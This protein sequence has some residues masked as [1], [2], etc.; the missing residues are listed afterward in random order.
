VKLEVAVAET[1]ATS[2]DL[3]I[4]IAAEEV[5]KKFD[6][7]WNSYARYAA[8]PGFRPGKVP[9]NVIKQRFAKDA[10]D[11]V[12]SDL[13]PHALHH[14]IMDHKLRVVGEP[15]VSELSVKEGEPLKFKVSVEIVPDFELKD[16]KSLRVTKKLRQV[17]DE[18]V[19]HTLEHLREN[20]AQ[21]V[22]VEDRVSQDGDYV[23][24]DLIGNYVDPK[25]KHE[26]E[27]IKAEGV[28]FEINAEGVQPEFTENL[29]GVRAGDIREFRVDYPE[30]FAAQG[31]AGKSV[32]FKAT[33]V[34]VKVRELPEINDEFAQE[35]SDKQ[36]LAELREQ[37]RSDQQ[38]QAEYQADQGV[39]DRLMDQLVEAHDFPVPDVMI[40]QQAA[41]LSRRY[42][43]TLM[44]LRVP[45]EE[46]KQINWEERAKQDRQRAVRDV[47][48]ALVVGRV[49][50]AENITVTKEEMETEITRMAASMR[51][52]P[53]DLKAALTKDDALSSIENRL[54]YQKTLDFVVSQSEV[55][56]EEFTDAQLEDQTDNQESAQASG[57]ATQA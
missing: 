37:I 36:T 34:S 20:A 52:S 1:A 7:T 42:L 23:T 14:A 18:S 3:T 57:E 21:L 43:S 5:K 12:V 4:E 11:N 8:V 54:L 9:R 26:E 46:I 17:T 39:R 48:G 45:V 13:L 50:E 49:A 16:Y 25:E 31:L 32:D 33:V 41:E 15:R 2:R 24:V 53:E 28:E 27:E 47:R 30:S 56:V 35:M 6:E 19:E 10:R 55:T 44:Q 51:Q 38:Q 40:E 22:P 29:R